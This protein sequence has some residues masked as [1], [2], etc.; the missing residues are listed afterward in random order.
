[1]AA[2]DAHNGQ[3]EAV[4]VLW[5]CKALKLDAMVCLRATNPNE[6]DEQLEGLAR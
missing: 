4:Q 5:F 6:T 1:M 3:M 2:G